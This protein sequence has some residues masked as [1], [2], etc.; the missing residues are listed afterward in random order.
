MCVRYSLIADISGLQDRF[1]FDG[2]GLERPPSFNI[3]P[4]QEVLVTV[5]GESK[6]G[7]YMGWRLI[8]SWA[9][10]PSIGSRMIN[11]CT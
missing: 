3:A 6:H 8:S 4:T 5:G 1:E 10:D 7:G 11:A 9:K 2:E